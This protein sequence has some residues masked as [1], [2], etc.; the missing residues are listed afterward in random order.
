[1]PRF[2]LPLILFASIGL[3][4]APAHAKFVGRSLP[5][6]KVEKYTPEEK[7]FLASIATKASVIVG[8]SLKKAKYQADCISR[9]NDNLEPCADSAQILQAVKNAYS[10]YR[11]Y[12]IMSEYSHFLT[13]V[14]SRSALSLNGS[15]LAQ[16]RPFPMSSDYSSNPIWINN[17]EKERMLKLRKD[18]EAFIANAKDTCFVNYDRLTEH[19]QRQLSQ[20]IT[21][22]PVVLMI[23]SKETFPTNSEVMTG[24][25]ELVA[26]IQ[27]TY[28]NFKNY[29][30]N[31]LEGL[32]AYQMLANIVAEES[33]ANKKIFDQLVIK[34]EP[35]GAI[36]HIGAWIK[37]T[38]FSY[39]ILFIGCTVVAIVTV[40]PVIA[41]ACA[42]ANTLMASY[43]V[44][45]D[46][47]EVNTKRSQ[48]LAGISGFEDIATAKVQA[49]VD[50]VLLLLNVGAGAVV[51]KGALGNP[52][53]SRDFHKELLKTNLE[54]EVLRSKANA[55]VK[56]L[57]KD[58]GQDQAK[59]IIGGTLIGNTQY[60]VNGE[61]VERIS[62]A[63]ADIIVE[64][65]KKGLFTYKDTA[66][67]I[68][69]L[70]GKRE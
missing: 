4:L 36:E 57:L 7:Q 53:W 55:Y 48:W 62:Q 44:Y 45:K 42:L 66:G 30:K 28:D 51:V 50:T 11:T 52:L 13:R 15:A 31:D 33:P 35:Q 8:D 6:A 56:D 5:H 63:S 23:S 41:M 20:I 67:A 16:Q 10:Q 32:W 3:S 14:R 2:L 69:K 19:Y 25:I 38:F 59:N 60:F 39:N 21:M 17:S 27:S 40:N 24:Y 43:T 61:D 68:C 58:Q 34:I 64:F 47:G 49:A 26:N 37:N 29:D 46:L 18:D 22:V 12:L 54:K 1:M 9:L 70:N 65:R